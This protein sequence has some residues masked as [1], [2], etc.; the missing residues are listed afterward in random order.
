MAE[1]NAPARL[2]VPFDVE[3][4]HFIGDPDA[5]I[6][7]VEYG[8][9]SCI[10]CHAAHEIIANLRDRFGDRMK[11][12]FRQLPI[13]GSDT[14]RPAADLAEFASECG[15]FWPVHDEL[16][17]RGP[18]FEPDDLEK[19]AGKYLLP[20]GEPSSEEIWE[21]ARRKVDADRASARASGARVTPSFFINDRRYDGAWDENA[22]AESMLGSLGHKIHSAGLD[23]LRWGPSTGLLLLLMSIAAVVAVNSPIGPGFERFWHSPLGIQTGGVDVF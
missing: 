19:I 16:M 12:V 9:Y 15:K 18:D 13:R 2:Q 5:E 20:T 21:R 3:T 8:S 4:D 7:L 23:F 6:T 1:T 11:Y 17:R 10:H 22:L 14:A